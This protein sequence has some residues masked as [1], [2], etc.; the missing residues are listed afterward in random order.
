MP[1]SPFFLA[2][3]PQ[4]EWGAHA[5][6]VLFDAPSRRTSSAGTFATGRR[7]PHAGRVCSPI[8]HPCP[9]VFIRGK[10][11]A[12]ASGDRCIVYRRERRCLRTATTCARPPLA[13]GQTF[14]SGTTL[15]SP[16]A[17]VDFGFQR[18]ASGVIRLGV[19]RSRG[20]AEAGTPN[21]RQ[22]LTV[23]LR[24]CALK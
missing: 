10:K 1:S 7:E 5:P 13:H 18:L 4:L 15:F 16:L 17:S 24:L 11:S 8:P 14:R 2:R 20:P 6:R 12:P 3:M 23:P 22:H 21:A 9:S 19:L